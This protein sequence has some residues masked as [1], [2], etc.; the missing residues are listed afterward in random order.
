MDKIVRLREMAARCI[1][2]SRCLNDPQD[3][4]R[5]NAFAAE[6]LQAAA[7]IEQEEAARLVNC[8]SLTSS[9]PSQE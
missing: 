9:T 7:M 4:A 1:R 3:V 5:F 2:L 6:S 8:K